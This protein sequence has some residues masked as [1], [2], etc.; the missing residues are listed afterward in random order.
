MLKNGEINTKG[1]QIETYYHFIFDILQKGKLLVSHIQIPK[2]VANSLSKALTTH[3]FLR[4][5]H[6]KK[7][8]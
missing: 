7:L 2:M 6:N 5:V 3:S 4:Y 8:D 1:K